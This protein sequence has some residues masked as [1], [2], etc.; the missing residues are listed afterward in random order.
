MNLKHFAL[1]A[2]GHYK[3]PKDNKLQH[4]L[5]WDCVKQVLIADDYQPDNRNDIISI[6]MSNIN[7]FIDKSKE[8]LVFDLVNGISPRNC[9]SIGY[10]TKDFFLAKGYLKRIKYDYQTAILYFYITKV[11]YMKADTFKDGLP[12]PNP[13]VLEISHIDHGILKKEKLIINL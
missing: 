1:F 7:K 3:W 9:Y 6:L 10:F 4:D 2:K 11:R 12:E 8:D 13:S 5:M